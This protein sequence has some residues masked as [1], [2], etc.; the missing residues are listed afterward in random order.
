MRRGCPRCKERGS[1][2]GLWMRLLYRHD[3]LLYGLLLEQGVYLS[4]PCERVIARLSCDPRPQVYECEY[5]EYVIQYLTEC[6]T[7]N[8]KAS[9]IPFFPAPVA[10]VPGSCSCNLGAL[11]FAVNGSETEGETCITDVGQGALANIN[12]DPITTSNKETACSCCGA[13]GAISA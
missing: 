5:Q 10:G 6:A 9:D 8:L 11:Y 3:E 13:S 2:F 7:T 4:L 1:L 12:N